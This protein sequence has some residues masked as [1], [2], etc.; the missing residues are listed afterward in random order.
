MIV[1]NGDRQHRPHL[2][3]FVAHNG[4]HY[5]AA[6]TEDRG[7]RFVDQRG[8]MRAADSAL[9]GNREG[10]ALQFIKRNF[11]RPG[12]LGQFCDFPG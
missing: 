11:S 7:I 4:F 9:V 8:E 12:F 5:A 1:G 3:L 6:Q 10:A 2:D